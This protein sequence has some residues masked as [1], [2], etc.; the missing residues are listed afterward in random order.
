MAP[1]HGGSR[2]SRAATVMTILQRDKATGFEVKE[3][4]MMI[5]TQQ[6]IH[7]YIDVKCCVTFSR[8]KLVSNDVRTHRI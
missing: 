1:S 4:E 5:Y 6:Y 8:N 3:K 7:R 2:F